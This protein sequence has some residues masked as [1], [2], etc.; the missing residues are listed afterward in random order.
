ML[1]AIYENSPG[2]AVRAFSDGAKLLGHDVLWRRQKD[3]FC[4]HADIAVLYGLKQVNLSL[5]ASCQ[6]HGVPT[7]VIEWGHLLRSSGYHQVN[8]DRLCWLPPVECPPDR[9]EALG[10]E[11]ATE[12]KEGGEYI[13]VCGQTPGDAQHNMGWPEIVEWQNKLLNRIKDITDRPIRYRPHPNTLISTQ[14][15]SFVNPETSNVLSNPLKVALKE[16]LEGAHCMVT[17]NSTCGQEALLMGVPV[18]CDPMAIYSGVANTDLSKLDN[19]EW[20]DTEDYFNRLAYSQWTLDEL[21]E[22][23]ALNFLTGNNLTG[24]LD[25]GII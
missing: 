10:L 1:I 20:H 3:H 17:F 2:D 9:F 7:V 23:G 15:G 16:D 24:G 22:G 21:A 18:F 13:L 12:R 11:R 5:L 8:I 25:H 19:P 6:A 14:S 4:A